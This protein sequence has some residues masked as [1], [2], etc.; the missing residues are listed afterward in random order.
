[1]DE[2]R[3]ENCSAGSGYEVTKTTHEQ[4]C[5]KC[6]GVMTT[7]S[8]V[9]YVSMIARIFG[10]NGSMMLLNIVIHVSSANIVNTVCIH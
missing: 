2:A 6:N 7:E 5:Q 3:K 10:E 8:Y 9:Q 4:K 1:M